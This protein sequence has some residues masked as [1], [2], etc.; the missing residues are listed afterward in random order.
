[1]RGGG[2]EDHGGRRREANVLAGEERVGGC[3]GWE[4]DRGGMNGGR[5]KEWS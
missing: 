3:C 1:M 5:G 4:Q 2:R